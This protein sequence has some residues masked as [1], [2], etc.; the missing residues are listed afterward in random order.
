M[1]APTIIAFGSDEQ[2]SQW[3]QARSGSPKRSGASS[4]AS[5]AREATSRAWPPARSGTATTGSS[6][7]QKVWTSLAHHAAGACFWRAPTR[8]CPSTRASATSSP[9]CTHR[10]SRSA[11][12]AS[13]PGEAEFQRGLPF[14]R[15]RPRRNRLGDVGE[16]WRVAKRHV[17]ERA[18]SSTR[19]WHP[20]CPL[21]H[22][23]LPAAKRRRQRPEPPH[24]RAAP[25]PAVALGTGGGRRA[26]AGAAP[27]QQLAGRAWP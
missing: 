5:R 14:R 1:A 12:C 27:L 9:T 18:A 22:D 20:P 6:N 26:L 11:R 2:K 24:P 19:Q 23:R 8:T 10:A 17:M 4:S 15:P 3:A 7:G 21:E 13:S 16:G 25:A